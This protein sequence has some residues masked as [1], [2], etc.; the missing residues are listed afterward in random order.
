MDR[1]GETI[2]NVSES[3]GPTPKM[4]GAAAE[5]IHKE[6]CE[7]VPI[8]KLQERRKWRDARLAALAKVKKDMAA[9]E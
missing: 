6:L 4:G 7:K 2:Y 8:E 5:Q 1:Y 3:F 9:K